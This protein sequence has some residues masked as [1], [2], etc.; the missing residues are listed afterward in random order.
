MKKAR[1]KHPDFLTFRLGDLAAAA[2]ILL[3]AAGLS[4]LFLHTNTRAAT[5]EIRQNGVLIDTLP[6]SQ[7]QKIA[8]EGI[9]ANMI[10]VENGAVFMESSTCPGED[11]VHSGKITQAG[12]SIV[13]LPNRV[14]VRLTGASP[15]GVDISAG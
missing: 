11:C 6:L 8:V 5:V 12:Q 10:V 1:K 7:N 3:A 9:Y 15:D 2:G 13:C 14:E 4:L